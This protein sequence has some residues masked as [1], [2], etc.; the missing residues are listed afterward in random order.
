MCQRHP[1]RKNPKGL[2][3]K[4]VPEGFS[5]NSSS[6]PVSVRQ[7]AGSPA[8]IERF[9]NL[10]VRKGLPLRLLAERIPSME[11]FHPDEQ[12]SWAG[13]LFLIIFSTIIEHRWCS[14]AIFTVITSIYL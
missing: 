8:G 1:Y 4:S 2:K 10:I 5:Y 12:G 13:F 7:A 14:Y 6:L 3:K 11:Q 9:V